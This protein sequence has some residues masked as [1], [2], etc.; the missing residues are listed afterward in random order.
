VFNEE[1]KI[2][3]EEIEDHP[4]EPLLNQVIR[5]SSGRVTRPVHKF[6][7]Q[8]H[9]HLQTQ[10]TNPQEYLIETTTVIAK[11]INKLNYQFAQTY[12]LKKGIKEFG[13]RGY[14]AAH[15]EMK[16]RHDRVVFIPI[17]I[18]ELKHVKRRGAIKSLIYLTEKKYGQSKDLSLLRNLQQQ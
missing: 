5:T 16:Q 13:E 2:Q 7:T 8:H 12:S 15:K 18:E 17:L 10:A 1:D 4:E 6:V 14:K 11:T 9:S 3:E